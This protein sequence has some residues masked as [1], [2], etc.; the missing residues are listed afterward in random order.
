MFKLQ[1]A[2]LLVKETEGECVQDTVPKLNFSY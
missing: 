2:G 1:P